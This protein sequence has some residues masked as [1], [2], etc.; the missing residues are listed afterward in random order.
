MVELVDNAQIPPFLPDLRNRRNAGLFAKKKRIV[1]IRTFTKEKAHAANLYM[2]GCEDWRL[3]SHSFKMPYYQ[4]R[5]LQ[6]RAL[7]R[8]GQSGALLS[9]KSAE[10]HTL[11]EHR[12]HGI[13]AVY[14]CTNVQ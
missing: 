3:Y 4:V 5:K 10:E 8:V 9:T 7:R 2:P 12:T 1:G 13:A 14:S 11:A 6:C